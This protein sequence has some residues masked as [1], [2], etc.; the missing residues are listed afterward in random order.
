MGFGLKENDVVKI[1]ALV[2]G[3]ILGELKQDDV[4]E[5][6]RKICA[7]FDIAK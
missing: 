2:V 7:K 3:I 6:V 5:E 1:C 4:A